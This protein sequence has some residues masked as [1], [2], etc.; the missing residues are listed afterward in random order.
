[1]Y[2]CADTVLTLDAGAGFDFYDWSTGDTTQTIEINIISD[3]TIFVEVGDT[4]LCYTIDSIVV[5]RV[6]SAANAA[7]EFT[8]DS[9]TVSFNNLSLNATLYTWDFGDSTT[10]NEMSPVHTYDSNGTYIV[11]L[12]AD[13][14]CNSD[15][16]VDTVTITSVG[17]LGIANSWNIYPNPVINNL[18]ISLPKG[19]DGTV[20]VR[21]ILGREL[22]VRKAEESI[23]T[24]EISMKELP[25]G[26]YFVILQNSNGVYEKKLLKQ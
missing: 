5:D 15:T 19:F 23:N 16:S 6:D 3:T 1:M 20:S 2:A 26:T 22:L 17:V 10:S 8:V 13:N 9:N 11:T 4:N 18:T 24:M 12:I 14:G 21:D 7:F 25:S